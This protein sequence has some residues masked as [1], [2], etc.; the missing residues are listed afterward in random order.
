[1][2]KLKIQKGFTLIEILIAVAIM[3]ILSA[4]A[5]ALVTNSGARR[6]ADL[7]KV[8]IFAGTVKNKLAEN[9]VGEWT[10]D[11]TSGNF[12]NIS[13]Y[14]SD[15]IGTLSVTP[16]TRRQG[17]TYCVSGNCL[18]FAGN[19]TT[20]NYVSVSD[21]IAL[22]PTS[23]ITMEAWVKQTGGGNVQTLDGIF[24]GK[25]SNEY[26]YL[27]AKL[28]YIMMSLV[29]GTSPGTQRQFSTPVGSFSLNQWYHVVG[30]YDGTT[31]QIYI[32]GVSQLSSST[33]T[34]ALNP[35]ANAFTLGKFSGGGYSFK[36]LLDE[37]RVYN[38]NL[39]ISQIQENY[40][41]G[42]NKLLANNGISGDEYNQRV[43]SLHQSL[44][45]AN[46]DNN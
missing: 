19:D 35:Q 43:T 4:T 42:L 28:T 16:P 3:A 33:Y 15:L 27:D 11:E 46:R 25:G 20:N 26:Y 12:M 44:A 31:A 45:A 24:M 17:S 29:I 18:E 10:L 6:Q 38:K 40:L 34:G 23:A 14:G 5:L 32:N 39:T 13:N 8:K 30:T 22:N 41:A 2:K 1:M 21:N 36:G 7:T 37:V 9:L